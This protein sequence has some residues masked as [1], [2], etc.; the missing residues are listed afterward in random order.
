MIKSLSYTIVFL[1]NVILS[2]SLTALI[3]NSEAI[4]EE[5]FS[6]RQEDQIKKM[7]LEAI[8]ENPDIL[9]EVSRILKERNDQKKNENTSLLLKKYKKELFFE[10]DTEVLG[11]TEGDITIVEFFDYNCSYCK[12]AAKKYS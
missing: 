6:K 2:A 9:V 7:A 3:F 8:L 12:V 11:N 5:I 10:K 1:F 4:S